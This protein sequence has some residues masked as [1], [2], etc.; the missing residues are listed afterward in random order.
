MCRRG[1][2][3]VEQQDASKYVSDYSKDLAGPR[4]PGRVDRAT[5]AGPRWSGR[6]GPGRA[7]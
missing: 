3:V 4:W 7:A 1:T 6:V 2:A 5:L